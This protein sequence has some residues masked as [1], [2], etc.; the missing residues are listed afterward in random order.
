MYAGHDIEYRGIEVG[1]RSNRSY[2]TGLAD[3]FRKDFRKEGC[4]LR[5]CD[6]LILDRFG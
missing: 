3:S 6:N 4:F 5:R 2:L 1:Q